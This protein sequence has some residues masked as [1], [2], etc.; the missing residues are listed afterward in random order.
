MSGVAEKLGV[1]ERKAK[2]KEGLTKDFSCD[3][4]DTE[5]KGIF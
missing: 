2:S 4:V 5:Q 1:K 3:T